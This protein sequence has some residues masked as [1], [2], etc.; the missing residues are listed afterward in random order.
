MDSP[1][2]NTK[3]D[4]LGI[5]Q[6]IRTIIKSICDNQIKWE[7]AQAR[8]THLCQII[9]KIKTKALTTHPIETLYPDELNAPCA[10][11]KIITTIFEDILQNAKDSVRQLEAIQKMNNNSANGK[12][13]KT[14]SLIDFIK[15]CEKLID[16]YTQE[17]AVKLKI[18][19]NIAHSQST[20]EL[21]IACSLWEFPCFVNKNS[22]S[23]FVLLQ[24]ECDIEIKKPDS[25]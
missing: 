19:I 10:K 22:K 24:F 14:W 11:L 21:I 8:G 15:C 12:L 13:F 25:K 9:E 6:R 23:N 16:I 17:L 18:M 4:L 20:K 3:S 7:A 2:T 5:K 1:T